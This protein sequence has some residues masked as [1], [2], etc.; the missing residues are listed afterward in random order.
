VQAAPFC[1]T[2]NVWPAIVSDPV[3]CPPEL[4]DT[5]YFTVPLPVPLA[6]AQPVIHELL[7]AA[8]QAQPAAAVTSTEPSAMLAEKVWLVGLSEYTQPAFCVTEN[9]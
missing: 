5:V 3:R 4:A 9:A 8:V 1:V 7:L 2:L 6:P